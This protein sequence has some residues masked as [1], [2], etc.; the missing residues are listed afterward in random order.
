MAVCRAIV[1][2]N[3]YCGDIPVS[4][5]A[6]N[7]S[8]TQSLSLYSSTALHSNLDNFH[9]T[10]ENGPGTGRVSDQDLKYQEVDWGVCISD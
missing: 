6:S 1:R 9:K 2:H 5:L 8:R 7:L 10:R 4:P 3:Y